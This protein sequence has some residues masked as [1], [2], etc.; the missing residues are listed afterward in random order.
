VV[1]ALVASLGGCSSEWDRLDPRLGG[2]GGG[3]A[4]AQG[5]G[6][7]GG[8]GG[9]CEDGTTRDC[10]TGAVAT[11]DVGPCHGGTE[12]CDVGAWGPCE[13]EVVPSVEVCD[14]ADNDCD[15]DVDED[16]AGGCACAAG[17]G[18]C[19]GVPENGCETDLTS[20]P[21]H[22]GACT[23]VCATG[24]CGVTISADMTSAPTDWTFNGGAHWDAATQTAVL[25]E[26]LATQAG[27]VFYDHPIDTDEFTVSFEFEIGGGTGAD[28]MAFAFTKDGATGLGEAG[29]GLG[30]TGL[31]G[32]GAELD[33]YDNA[34]CGDASAN[35][36]AV[37]DLTQCGLDLEPTPLAVA[38]ADP[39]LLRE[40]GVHAAVVE[41]SGGALSVSVDGTP[42]VVDAALPGFVPGE[43][44]YFGFGAGTGGSTDRHE[45]RN[46]EFTFPS[47]RCL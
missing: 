25:V 12:T 38:E 42:L 36:V 24:A 47:A 37:I 35:H 32:F 31:V 18:D 30:V 21:E 22:C 4:G 16:V 29:G 39:I 9:A 6:G 5:G 1:A 43:A 41:L 13:G 19:D 45:V 28:G 8:A 46:V 27:T 11:E 34:E 7:S 17:T 20:S 14:S 2:A 3:G 23:N 40:S 33:T 10:Y 44:Y 26:A 15:G